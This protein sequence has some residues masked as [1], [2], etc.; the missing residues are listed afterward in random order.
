M[1]VNNQLTLEKE[2][3]KE[4]DEENIPITEKPGD[5]LKIT[6]KAVTKE[7]IKVGDSKSKPIEI[8]TI[9]FEYKLYLEDGQL[10][11]SSTDKIELDIGESRFPEAFNKCIITMRKN[12]T[13][14]FHIRA[15]YA[16]KISI[17]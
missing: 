4:D 1:I 15:K 13:S 16:C 11:D 5:I 6:K 3:Q 2:D 14:K 10:I 7:I 8:D 17:I 9:I 12:E